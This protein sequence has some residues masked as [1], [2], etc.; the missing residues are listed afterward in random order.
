MAA[1]R[2]MVNTVNPPVY[3]IFRTLPY[4]S[5]IFRTLL[6]SSVLL[7]TLLC[8]FV[9]FCTPAAPLSVPLSILLC[10]PLC[11]ALCVSLWILLW[12][13]CMPLYPYLLCT[14][15]CTLMC[16]L[17]CAFMC[18]LVDPCVFPYVY[19][20]GQPCMPSTCTLM[21]QGTLRQ[22][23]QFP[24]PLWKW[25]RGAQDSPESAKP[26]GRSR[27][28]QFKLPRPPPPPLS[29]VGGPMGPSRCQ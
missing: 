5:G 26:G 1:T 11:V 24:P 8:S 10:V 25:T 6:Y 29:S 7:C 2:E 15:M 3:F 22:Q 14:L 4:S 9:L 20:D 13:L 28:R 16:V 27:L 12:P 17:A 21:Q 18:V 19:A 23:Q